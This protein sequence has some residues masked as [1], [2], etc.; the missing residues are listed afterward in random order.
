MSFR[1]TRPSALIENLESRRLYSTTPVDL[2]GQYVAYDSSHHRYEIDLN[3]SR[4]AVTGDFRA[5]GLDAAIS[6]TESGNTAHGTIKDTSG[7]NHVF[8]ATLSGHTLYMSID[9]KG[10]SAYQ[11]IT[12]VWQQSFVTHVA[13]GFSYQA[14][15]GWY[16]KTSADG[17]QIVSPDG[18]M[19]AGIVIGYENGVTSAHGVV[20]AFAA[21]GDRVLGETAIGQGWLG[22]LYVTEEVVVLSYV[23]SDGTVY[24]S[25]GLV[26]TLT[27]GSQ[28]LIINK[29]VNAP[30]SSFIK[31]M[32]S[33]F[34]MIGSLQPLNTTFGAAPQAMPST[35]HHHTVF[36]DDGSP[37]PWDTSAPEWW[38]ISET[39]YQPSYWFDPS[40]AASGPSSFYSDYSQDL[41]N[42]ESVY[43]TAFLGYLGF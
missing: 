30:A 23:G 18:Q 34:R 2:S 13:S 7:R 15:A 3:Q 5:P 41:N 19:E 37:E 14:P 35:V 25:G 4:A 6:A 22:G 40:L 29:G 32:P 31:A 26:S 20:S 11:K 43:S 17:I 36:G 16:S 9:R 12:S 39:P 38:G 28:T 42:L 21:A 27:D 10:Y 24:L 1:N 8:D 33:L